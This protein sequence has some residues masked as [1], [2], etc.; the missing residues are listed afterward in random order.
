MTSVCDIIDLFVIVSSA[1]IGESDE[2]Y[3]QAITGSQREDYKG[4]TVLILGLWYSLMQFVYLIQCVVFPGGGDCGV[5]RE[6]LKHSPK[7]VT[8]IEVRAV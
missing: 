8:M 4:K 2:V 7:F 3:A 5:L 6:I 1:D